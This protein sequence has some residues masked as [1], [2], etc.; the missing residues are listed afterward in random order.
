M[1]YKMEIMMRLTTIMMAMTGYLLTVS[2]NSGQ[3]MISQD[4]ACILAKVGS[5]AIVPARQS[6]LNVGDL[7][8]CISNDISPG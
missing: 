6:R 4:G 5:H 7:V 3:G 1:Q 8:L 2:T